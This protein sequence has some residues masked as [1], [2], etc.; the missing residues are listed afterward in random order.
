MRKC[1]LIYESKALPELLEA[2]E[3]KRLIALASERNKESGITGLLVFTGD[4]ILQALEGPT[5]YVNQLYNKIVVDPR[6]SEIELISY[7]SIDTALFYDWTMRLV[8]LTSVS[9][10]V[11]KLM[12]MKYPH[13]E[14]VVTI[15]NDAINALSLL[16]DAR[17]IGLTSA[18]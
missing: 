9:A 18:S 17:N 7:E 8:D 13:I 14:D 16:I 2:D 10:D 12:L 4:R 15:P 6:H 1:R 11:K 3:L 5:R